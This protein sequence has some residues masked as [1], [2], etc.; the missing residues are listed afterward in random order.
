MW[1]N[2]SQF[3]VTRHIIRLDIM[4]TVCSTGYRKFLH[5]LILISLDIV[6]LLAYIGHSICLK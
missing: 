6:V 2:G 3:Y 1:I 4:V 5:Y